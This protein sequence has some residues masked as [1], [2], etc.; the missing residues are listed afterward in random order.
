MRVLILSA[1][2]LVSYAACRGFG[3]ASP[4]HLFA[5]QTGLLIVMFCTILGHFAGEFPRGP[6]FAMVRLVGTV[7]A[8][9]GLLLFFLL[10][11]RRWDLSHR[12]LIYYIL[13]FY[14]IGLTTD[15]VL[16]SLK[17]WQPFTKIQSSEIA[18]N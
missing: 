4:E 9:S 1:V 8:R 2:L 11:T 7:F 16:S 3:W 6:Q 5:C 13:A 12:V 14:A 10:I 18:A 17:T 15:M